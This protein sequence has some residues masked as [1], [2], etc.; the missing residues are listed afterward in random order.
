M[1]YL[2]DTCVVSDFVKGDNPTLAKLQSLSPLQV[3]ISSIT[4]YELHYG[5]VKNT[6][7]KKGIKEAVLGFIKDVE[8][9]P[10][11]T[12]ESIIAAKIRA[13]LE[14]DGKPIGP[15]DVLIASTALENKLTLVTTNV[16]EFQRIPSLKIENWREG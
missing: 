9:L 12:D 6:N 13:N 8:I 2:L 4:A 1:N 7:L 3:K 11:R 5:L 14:N 16:S 10:F 15:Y